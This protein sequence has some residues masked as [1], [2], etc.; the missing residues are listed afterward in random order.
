MILKFSPLAYK[1]LMKY[2]ELADTEISGMGFVRQLSTNLFYCYDVEIYE[3]IVSPVNTKL[4]EKDLAKRATQLARENPNQLKDMYLWWHSHANMDV[5][6]SY[7]DKEEISRWEQ[8]GYG[9]SLVINKQED[10]IC[11]LDIFSPVRVV[12]PV[13][14]NYKKNEEI[15]YF[16]W[17]DEECQNEI[18]NKL[19]LWNNIK[20][21]KMFLPHKMRKDGVSDL[22]VLAGLG[23]GLPSCLQNLGLPILPF[24][25]SI[26]SLNIIYP[27]NFMDTIKSEKKK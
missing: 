14:I 26:E 21:K 18:N 15:N 23:V 3:Q 19:F 1:K 12:C 13:K 24:T 6:W 25:T 20:G 10:Y 9:I 16:P 2:V 27:P 8:T 7:V 17:L 22:S 4:L 11:Q 5:F